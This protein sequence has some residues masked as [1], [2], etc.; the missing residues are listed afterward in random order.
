[1]PFTQIK[2]LLF[3]LLGSSFLAAQEVNHWNLTEDDG[4]P[5]MVIYDILQ[6]HAGVIWFSTEN[7]ICYFDGESIV[8]LRTSI[9]IDN[10]ILKMREDRYHR[11]WI[12]NLSG[13]LAYVE[14]KQLYEFD[15][16]KFGENLYVDQITIDND[17]L[18]I[19]LVSGLQIDIYRIEIAE[20][21]NDDSF[22]KFENLNSNSKIF[23]AKNNELYVSHYEKSDKLPS[24]YFLKKIKVNNEVETVGSFKSIRYLNMAYHNDEDNM[25][26]LNDDT[27]IFTIK[28]G[29]KS[30]ISELDDVIINHIVKNGGFFVLT[31]KGFYVLEEQQGD[32]KLNSSAYFEDYVINDIIIDLEGNYWISTAGGGVF[33]IPNIE[34]LNFNQDNS[35]IAEDKVYELGKSKD[36]S[37]IILGHSRNNI[38]LFENNKITGVVPI[39]NERKVNQFIYDST[40]RFWAVCDDG[41]SYSDDLKKFKR[42]SRGC[43]KNIAF[44]SNGYTI[45]AQPNSCHIKPE[46]PSVFSNYRSQNVIIDRTYATIN[47]NE[48]IWIGTVNGLY[49]Y[50]YNKE[51]NLFVLQ[52]D[53]SDFS[54]TKLKSCE[55]SIIWV[56]TSQDGLFG[57]YDNKVA[58]HFNMKSGLSSNKVTDIF[59]DQENIWVGTINGVNKVDF[60]NNKID[61]INHY[62]GLPSN[63]INA[64][65][66]DDG[67]LYTGTNKGFTKMPLESVRKN[68]VPPIINFVNFNISD[69]DTTWKE[70]YEIHHNDNDISISFQG[71][72]YRAR[73]SL[74]YKYMLENFDKT[75]L[76]SKFNTVRYGNLPP[77]KYRFVA[78]ALNEDNVESTNPI[79][80]NFE[81][82]T[83]WWSRLWFKIL[84]ILL[85]IGLIGLLFYLRFRQLR[86][87]ER[88]NQE[89][90]QKINDLRMDALQNQMNPHFMFNALNSIQLY[91]SKNDRKLAMQYLSKFSNLMRLIMRFSRIKL[92]TLN[93]ELKFLKM[94]LDLEETRFG[95]KIKINLNVDDYLL[96]NADLIKIPP[97]LVQP[98]IENAFK[99]GLLH[100]KEKGN[101]VIDFQHR[102][103]VIKVTV[104]DDGVGREAAQAFNRWNNRKRAS[105]GLLTT[106]QRLEIL[107]NQDIQTSK[108]KDVVITDLI[109]PETG[110]A[111]G[112]KIELNINIS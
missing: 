98:I 57:I 15:L 76:Y 112:T 52:N 10:S 19:R 20:K 60:K 66:V 51:P 107:N 13:Q 32:F 108:P 111:N 99:H 7:G 74:S 71:I 45:Y 95:E 23:Y 91:I 42:A 5:S 72:A 97:L 89:F 59:P 24:I 110:I 48:K 94:Y 29:K 105:T 56:G 25:I 1:M 64:L 65:L 96:E 75:F 53:R 3:V 35:W 109:N 26:L 34:S 37:N 79:K 92:I 62:D 61:M 36:G 70:N 49:T 6:D 12:Y 46:D 9:L 63:E 77:G 85:L 50:E 80:L 58:Y 17:F 18:W 73:E 67:Y 31:N 27:S 84:S 16:S 106:T 39:D 93:E 81:I 47:M 82:L 28:D 2:I 38:S 30:T 41:I 21:I 103:N 101:L 90:Q 4:L 69:V 68:E 83:P 100:K 22:H 44:L 86:V 78:Y 104:Q 87:K 14:N 43:V 55:D 102:E 54:I 8:T 33:I 40:G 11:I 88:T